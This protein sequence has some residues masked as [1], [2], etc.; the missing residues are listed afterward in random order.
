MGGGEPLF[1]S[2]LRE[3][4][5]HVRSSTG[6]G[7]SERAPSSSS[8]SLS[9][10]TTLPPFSPVCECVCARSLLLFFQFACWGRWRRSP[11]GGAPFLRALLRPPSAAASIVRSFASASS[12]SLSLRPLDL[13]LRRR[14]VVEEGGGGGIERN[15]RFSK[16]EERAERR[17]RTRKEGRRRHTDPWRRDSEG[18]CSV[19]A[20]SIQ[21]R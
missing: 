18:N 12:L 4:E 13:L 8:S 2:L 17:G 9:T 1:L 19:V 5:A 10:L 21:I 7:R 11:N 3:G 14:A 6:W 15:S 20:R 16:A